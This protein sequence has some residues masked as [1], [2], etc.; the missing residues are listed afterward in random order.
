[1]LYL[2]L[3]LLLVGI[4]VFLRIINNKLANSKSLKNINRSIYV[5]WLLAFIFLM[6]NLGDANKYQMLSAFTFGGISVASLFVL[7]AVQI[8]RKFKYAN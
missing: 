7:I 8:V 3:I 2:I 1:M 4:L 6:S 5:V